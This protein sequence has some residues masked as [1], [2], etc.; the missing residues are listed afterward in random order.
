MTNEY[1]NML[2]RSP[3]PSQ[4]D[5]QALRDKMAENKKNIESVT[6]TQKWKELF[7]NFVVMSK[8]LSDMMAKDRLAQED[9]K[10]AQE[11][12]KIKNE[13]E[14]NNITELKIN[15]ILAEIGDRPCYE[16]QEIFIALGWRIRSGYLT[17]AQIKASLK[18]NKILQSKHKKVL[19]KLSYDHGLPTLDMWYCGDHEC[20]YGSSFRDSAFDV[21]DD[22][23]HSFCKSFMSEVDESK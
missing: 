17:A 2:R 13:Q 19:V 11:A 12:E 16:A 10:K 22:Y 8:Q 1:Y 3:A 9:A 4:A 14:I 7:D 21:D 15:T 20:Y 5:I 6:S 23:V 18:I